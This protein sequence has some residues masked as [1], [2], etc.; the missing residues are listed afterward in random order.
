MAAVCLIHPSMDIH[1]NKL[2]FGWSA[3][4]F[5]LEIPHLKVASEDSLAVVGASGCGKT[6]FLRLLAGLILPD[7]GEIFLNGQD[8]KNLSEPQCRE[9]RQR[10]IGFVYQDFRLM[11]Y[12]NMKDNI[13]LPWRLARGRGLKDTL[14]RDRLHRL[15]ES[16]GITHLMNR[17]LDRVSSGERQRVAIARALIM[18]PSL[19]LADEPTGNLDPENKLMVCKLLQDK[20]QEYGATLILVTHDQAI[21]D[22]FSHSVDFGTFQ[23]SKTMEKEVG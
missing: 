20:A 5:S 11:D 4:T 17:T 15:I 10:H 7:G 21:V 22:R 18:G 1:I 8:L 2:H 3:S 14:V 6:T 12:L 13:L 19:L 9:F 16:L 23:S